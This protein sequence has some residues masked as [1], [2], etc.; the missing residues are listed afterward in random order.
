M[1]RRFTLTAVLCALLL[2]PIACSQHTSI[3]GEGKKLSQVVHGSVGMTGE[4]HRLTILAGSD[5]TKL[6]IVG[7]DIEVTIDPGARVR[8]IEIIG[9]DNEIIAPADLQFE[10]SDIGDENE[11]K[12]R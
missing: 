11:V 6:S 9:D 3:T 4:D 5:V 10:F 7:E 12:R 1:T 8:K 2:T